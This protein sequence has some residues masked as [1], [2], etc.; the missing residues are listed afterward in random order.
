MLLPAHR[1]FNRVSKADT[2]IVMQSD[3]ENYQALVQEGASEL[4]CDACGHYPLEP[5]HGHFICPACHL[6][7]KCC[8]G[9]PVEAA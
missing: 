2:L 3:D 7:T 8:E 9:M 6:P 5:V 4:Y 1:R